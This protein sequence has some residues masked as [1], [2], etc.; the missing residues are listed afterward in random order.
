MFIETQLL[1]SKVTILKLHFVQE[2]LIS[3]ELNSCARSLLNKQKKDSKLSKSSNKLK[4]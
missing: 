2:V 1:V 3:L 4:R